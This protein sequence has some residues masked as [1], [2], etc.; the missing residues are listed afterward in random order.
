[1]EPVGHI[2]AVREHVGQAD[3]NSAVN[4]FGSLAEGVDHAKP[5][6]ARDLTAVPSL[7][8]RLGEH[9]LRERRAEDLP[10]FSASP[11]VSFDP[12][13]V[14]DAELLPSVVNDPPCSAD[15]RC[16]RAGESGPGPAGMRLARG[17]GRVRQAIPV[18]DLVRG[19][20]RDAGP[21]LG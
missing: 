9:N 8:R 16:D 6:P 14:P 15:Y 12:A 17:L 21:R 10:D 4:D 19:A 7:E 20:G 13:P 18:V 3:P 1:M 11:P 2:F 5:D